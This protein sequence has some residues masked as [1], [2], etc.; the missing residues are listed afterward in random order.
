MERI[1]NAEVYLRTL[2][3]MIAG[4]LALGLVIELICLFFNKRGYNSIGLWYGVLMAAGM[5]WHM[6]FS[7]PKSVDR[8]EGG[9]RKFT[10]ASSMIRYLVVVIVYA[11]ICY[12]D[13]GSPLWAFA[14]IMTLKVSVYLQPFTH[15]LFMKLFSWQE[16]E[17][18]PY[19]PEEDDIDEN[20]Y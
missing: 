17:Y 14:G 16:I 3:E 8:G 9:A 2:I 11:A 10:T 5:A 18:P 6:W 19:E 20:S 1:K 13:F 4:I 12:F 7:V 15:K